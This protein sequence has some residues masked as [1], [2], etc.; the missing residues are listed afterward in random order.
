MS[1]RTTFQSAGRL[2]GAGLL[3]AA[4]AVPGAFATN[5]DEAK[6]N[7]MVCE[8]PTGYLKAT[9]RATADVKS[10][11]ANINSKRQQEYARIANEHGVTPEQVGKLT[12]QK[13]SPKCQ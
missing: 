5:L 12:A 1:I 3:L 11:V 7:G 13:L 8:M 9:A 4:L 6:K 10:M 2:L